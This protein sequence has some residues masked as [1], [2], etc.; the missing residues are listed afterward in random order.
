MPSKKDFL[1]LPHFEHQLNAFSSGFPGVLYKTTNC[2][3]Q[4]DSIK[5]EFRESETTKS[6]PISTILKPSRKKHHYAITPSPPPTPPPTCGSCKL[7]RSQIMIL[8]SWDPVKST[9]PTLQRHW[10]KPLWPA[11]MWTQ[12]LRTSTF[13]LVVGWGGLD[14][15]HLDVIFLLLME[16]ILR[17][18]VEVGS[19]PSVIYKVL[20]IPGG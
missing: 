9:S 4:K 12:C 14:V 7:F 19:L 11:K 6:W 5:I 16:E 2:Q 8:Q 3:Q 17:S 18:P 13:P 10:T 1:K 20:Y 15:N